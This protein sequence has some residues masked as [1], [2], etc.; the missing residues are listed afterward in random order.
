M[1][2]LVSALEALIPPGHSRA[3]RRQAITDLVTYAQVHFDFEESLMDHYELTK[4][5]Q[6]KA[7][8]KELLTTVST[9]VA[10]FET[11]KAK[12][13]PELITY[14]RTWLKEHI[15]NNDAHLAQELL[16]KGV[17]SALE[18]P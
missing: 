3:A 2:D 5:D 8:H 12:I 4:A 13:T 10:S 1:Q 6:H 14:L 11:G 18:C 7:R 16:A 9:F 15:L 17:K